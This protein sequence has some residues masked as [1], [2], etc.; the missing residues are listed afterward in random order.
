VAR[1]SRRSAADLSYEREVERA[2]KR[3]AELLASDPSIHRHGDVTPERDY[4]SIYLHRLD[5]G[6][7]FVAHRTSWDLE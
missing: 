7:G 1:T 4:Y 2:Y 6:G 5:R 3:R